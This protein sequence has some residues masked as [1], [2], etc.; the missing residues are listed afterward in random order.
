MSPQTPVKVRTDKLSRPFKADALRQHIETAI[1]SRTFQTFSLVDDQGPMPTPLDTATTEKCSSYIKEITEIAKSEKDLYK[2]VTKL[3]TEISRFVHARPSTKPLNSVLTDKSSLIMF[4]IRA[5]SVQDAD[6]GEVIRPDIVGVEADADE[7][8]DY[9]DKNR[10][11]NR[12]SSLRWSQLVS[13]GEIK[14]SAMPEKSNQEDL[15]QLLSYVWCTNR[16]QPNRF[17]QT[18]IM[19]YKTGFFTLQCLPDSAT[20][21]WNHSYDNHHALFQYIYA[22][23]YPESGA[24][25]QPCQFTNLKPIQPPKITTAAIGLKPSF[26]YAVRDVEYSVFDLFHGSGFS[27]QVYVGLGATATRSTG[28]PKVIVLKVYCRDVTRRFREEEILQEIHKDGYLPGVPRISKDASER[29]FQFPGHKDHTREACM[30]PLTTTGESLSKCKDVLQFLKAMYDL[31][32]VHRV[33]VETKGIL[34]RDIS[35]A[36]ILINYQHFEGPDEID[37]NIPFIDRILNQRVP[38]VQVLL[39]DFDNAMKIHGTGHRHAPDEAKLAEQRGITGTPAFIAEVLAHPSLSVELFP[40][41]RLETLNDT[42]PHPR[43]DRDSS[44]KQF[45]QQ[46]AT[47]KRLDDEHVSHQAIH[48]AE[49][50]FWV[51][52]FFMVRANPKGSESYKNIEMRSETF[53]AIAEHEIGKLRSA[54]GAHFERFTEKRWAKML[55]DKLAGFSATLHELWRYFSFP[56]YGIQ[57]PP[58][59]QFHAHNFLQRL[60]FREIKR[61]IHMADSIELELAPLPVYS[62]L[63]GIQRSATLGPSLR[64]LSQQKPQTEDNSEAPPAKRMRREHQQSRAYHD[65]G[66]LSTA[67]DVPTDEAHGIQSYEISPSILADRALRKV[68]QDVRASVDLQKLW[69]TAEPKPRFPIHPL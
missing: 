52:V 39:T 19:A 42:I 66:A 67:A 32:E 45:F 54:R 22:L 5:N 34:H 30:V 29:P 3:L 44:D 49:S 60:L 27:R 14:L 40:F 53:E 56:W 58:E 36:N 25:L 69:F 57:V 28:I 43:T 62:S 31:T 7:V 11:P 26:N 48:D 65:E 16:Y 61:L 4:I 63:S 21:S 64:L 33:L 8:A 12:L 35:W 46:V 47:Y 50:I 51:I 55:P 37:L 17:L 23:Y 13:V 2:P 59:H 9:L 1:D 20:F 41:Q 6:D 15:V 10:L 18:A 38:K 68:V 24:N